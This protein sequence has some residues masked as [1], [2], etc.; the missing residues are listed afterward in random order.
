M[1]V[2]HICSDI[3]DQLHVLFQKR[4]QNTET[5]KTTEYRQCLPTPVILVKNVY[6]GYEWLILSGIL[7]E[8]TEKVGE[9]IP[10]FFRLALWSY[11]QSVIVKIILIILFRG[12]YLSA[13][14]A[15]LLHLAPACLSSL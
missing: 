5:A 3:T 15:E 14:D 2:G 7:R 1:A 11:F 8:G 6:K 4:C 9:N 10:V 13:T 12:N